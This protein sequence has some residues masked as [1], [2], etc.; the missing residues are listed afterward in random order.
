MI[1]ELLTAYGVSAVVFLALDA[2]WLG[3]VAPR[4]YQGEIGHLLSPKPDL[5]IAAIFYLVY[6]IGLVIFAMARELETGDVWRAAMFGALFGFFTYATYDMTNLAT[7]NGFTWKVA[8]VDITWGTFLSATA[9]ASGVWGV[10]LI[11]GA[12]AST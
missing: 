7:M 8:L 12:R 4:F 3:L 11:L 6:V 9:A 2:L 5:A 1:K 10:T